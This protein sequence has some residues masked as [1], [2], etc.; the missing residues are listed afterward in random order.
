ML[1]EGVAT[2]L[3]PGNSSLCPQGGVIRPT[4]RFTELIAI[5]EAGNSK[6]HASGADYAGESKNN[7]L[8]YS[9]QQQITDSHFRWTSTARLPR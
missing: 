4:N 9:N 6:Q 7:A 2:S 5:D 3:P 1:R 8:P